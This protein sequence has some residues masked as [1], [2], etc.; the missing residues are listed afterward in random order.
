MNP[1]LGAVTSGFILFP[2]TA[3]K[4]S[5]QKRKQTTFVVNGRIRVYVTGK[6]T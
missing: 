6:I 3:T 5:Q 1:D 4:V 2:I